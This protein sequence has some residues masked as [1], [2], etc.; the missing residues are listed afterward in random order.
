MR[1][2]ATGQY[3]IISA[4]SERFRAFVPMPMPLPPKPA[5]VWSPALRRRFDDALLA[6]GRL[7]AVTAL[8]PMRRLAR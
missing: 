2:R 4:A 1:R 8:L 5:P 7:D 6:L 3:R